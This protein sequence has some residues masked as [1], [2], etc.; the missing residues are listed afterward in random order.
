M[1]LLQSCTKP[2]IWPCKYNQT[3]GLHLCKDSTFAWKGHSWVFEWISNARKYHITWHNNNIM[4]LGNLHTRI[5][6]IKTLTLNTN[7]TEGKAVIFFTLCTCCPDVCMLLSEHLE[8]CVNEP[9]FPFVSNFKWKSPST[10]QVTCMWAI[11]HISDAVYSMFCYFFVCK[12]HKNMSPCT[13]SRVHANH[14]QNASVR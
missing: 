1:E 12:R 9:L 10:K 11:Y 13:R 4:E 2:S 6:K 14:K 3:P 5:L 8:Q 7:C